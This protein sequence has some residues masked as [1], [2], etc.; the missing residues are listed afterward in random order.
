MLDQ[1]SAFLTYC[2]LELSL[3]PNT[4]SAYRNDLELA[5]RAMAELGLDMAG[6]GPDEV[7]RIL[8]HLRDHRGLAAASLGRLL[9]TM[10]M[11]TRYLVMERHLV[12]D[13]VQLARLPHLWSN[14]P[15]IL[16]V[17]EVSRLIASAPEGPLQERDALALELLYASGGRASEIVGI[18]LDDLREGRS[19]LSL[20]GKGSKERLVPLGVPARQACVRYLERCRPRLAGDQRTAH[21]LLG[22][23]GGALS[24][25]ELWRVVVRAGELAGITK[26]IY[27][28]LLRHS[29]ATHLLEH[30]ADLRSVQ[31]LLGHA[32]LT[33]TQRY[34]Q[35]DAKRLIEL[36]RK[37][38][39]RS[40]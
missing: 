35:V 25:V 37:F 26:T 34:T 36:H 18:R 9:V 3:S 31:S 38:H 32:N 33:T 8:G 17:A 11:Y 19:L 21:L 23:R 6:I 12:R 15:E 16:S 14:L 24:R 27:P 4:L 30:G 10:R 40:R 13:R 39:P 29:F 1:R 22:A 7:G 2:R 5:T 28:H 20:R